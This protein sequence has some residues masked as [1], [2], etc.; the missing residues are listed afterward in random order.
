[1]E[2][3]PGWIYLPEELTDCYT[4][5]TSMTTFL[6]TI[7]KSEVPPPFGRGSI[8]TGETI[9]NKTFW[10]S[11][12][13]FKMIVLRPDIEMDLKRLFPFFR[14]VEP[15]GQLHRDSAVFRITSAKNQENRVDYFAWISS[16]G[17]LL[18][19]ED[20][21]LLKKMI[22]TGYG[23]VS[24]ILEDFPYP[25]LLDLLPN[26]G[27][28][29]SFDSYKQ[30][31]YAICQKAGKDGIDS[32]VIESYKESNRILAEPFMKLFLLIIHYARILL[33]SI[34]LRRPRM[35]IKCLSRELE[36]IPGKKRSMMFWK[37]IAS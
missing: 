27:A 2:E 4:S 34:L 36:L 31:F 11:S 5:I 15:T 29:L 35:I 7:Y 19:C 14:T 17:E 24:C 26:L 28:G 20:L 6:V 16:E 30:A 33:F 25:S 22:A 10:S 21:K 32:E 37:N 12:I 1:M 8:I 23:D 3:W 13:G 9:D 18:L